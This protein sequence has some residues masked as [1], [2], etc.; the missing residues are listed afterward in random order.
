VAPKSKT[1]QIVDEYTE[2]IRSGRLKSGDRLPGTTAMLQKYD[3]GVMTV[4]TAVGL[5]KA[6]GLIETV[7]GVGTFVK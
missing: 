1:Q 7:P 6:A 4:R 2:E 3:V 5:L